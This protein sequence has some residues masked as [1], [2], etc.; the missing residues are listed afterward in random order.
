ML[1]TYRIGSEPFILSLSQGKHMS[2][3]GQQKR[4]ST[5]SIRNMKRDE[6]IVCLTSYTTPMT[7]LVDPHCDLLLV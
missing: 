2:V 6:P 7:K 3:H 4:L 1:P 5:A